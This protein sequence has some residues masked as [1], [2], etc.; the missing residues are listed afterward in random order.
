[1]SSERLRA[2]RLVVSD[3]IVE[4]IH[5]VPAKRNPMNDDLRADYLELLQRVEND[6][7]VRAVVITGAGGSFCAGGDLNL[8]ASFQGEDPS[9]RSASSTMR[10]RLRTAHRWLDRLRRLD[11]PVIAAVDG[12]AYGAG[13]GLALQ[14]DFLLASTRAVFCLSFVKIGAVPDFGKRGLTT[15]YP[16]TRDVGMLA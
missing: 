15:L 9:Q 4:F 7:S 6:S 12:A 16:L 5:D 11:V 13:A 8:V 10:E 14:A 3:G 2:A 1:M